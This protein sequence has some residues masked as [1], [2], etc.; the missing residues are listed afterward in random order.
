[1]RPEEGAYEG[2]FS[3]ML[4]KASDTST[5]LLSEDETGYNN[6]YSGS[7]VKLNIIP[8][9][10]GEYLL[11]LSGDAADGMYYVGVKSND[12]SELKSLGEPNNSIEEADAIGAVEPNA[13]GEVTT[14]MLFNADFPFDPATDQISTQFGDDLDYYKVELNAGDVMVAET[15]PVDGPLWPRDTDMFMELYNAAGEQIADND[16]GGFDWHSRIEY[17]A[18]AAGAVYVL[19]RSQDFEGATDRDPARA[20]YNLA[21]TVDDGTPVVITNTEDL[22]TPEK[23]ELSQNYPNPFNPTTTIAYSIPQSADVELAVYNILGQRVATLVSGFQVSGSYQVNF[24]ASQLAS[25]TYLYRIKAGEHVS[26]KRM[27]LVK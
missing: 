19:V 13:P 16:D 4:F 17:E 12:I 5:N 21:I 8:D 18:E 24:D 15:S 14:Y 2:A 7:N 27:V 1:M 9:E 22:E 3:A 11:Y 25:G 6:R 20:E 26:V 23:F 10:T